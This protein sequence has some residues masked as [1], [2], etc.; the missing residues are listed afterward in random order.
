MIC[1]SPLDQ[2]HC[3]PGC[4]LTAPYCH[5]RCEGGGGAAGACLLHPCS[6]SPYP[7][8]VPATCARLALAAGAGQCRQCSSAS[9]P[10]PASCQG[11]LEA[12]L[13]APCSHLSGAP[14][15]H[16]APS[17]QTLWTQCAESQ[18]AVLLSRWLK[19]QNRPFFVLSLQFF[20]YFPAM[21]SPDRIDTKNP[22]VR[23]LLRTQ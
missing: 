1:I 22:D 20:I 16:C 7:Q 18:A 19:K 12:S 6:A 3:V 23:E 17:L 5:G 9:A 2:G 13:P 8:Q 14:C 10:P 11:C 21:E 4:S 15:W